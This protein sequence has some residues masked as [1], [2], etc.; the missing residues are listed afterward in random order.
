M[1]A[2]SSWATCTPVNSDRTA[3][4]ILAILDILSGEGETAAE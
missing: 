3:A 1:V 4:C 2:P